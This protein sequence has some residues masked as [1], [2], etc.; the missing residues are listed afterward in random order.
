MTAPFGGTDSTD[1]GKSPF[2]VGTILG[3]WD[4]R[5]RPH[6]I[7]AIEAE[8]GLDESVYPGWVL[9]WYRDWFADT[10]DPEAK[11]KRS[12]DAPEPVEPMAVWP[13]AAS[14]AFRAMLDE[15]NRDLA[16]R[17]QWGLD[18]WRSSAAV[19]MR[20]D[21]ANGLQFHCDTCGHWLA[22]SHGHG[23][24]P[25]CGALMVSPATQQRWQRWYREG[26]LDRWDLEGAIVPA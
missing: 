21:D 23:R 24:C 3:E 19:A 5:F 17:A 15:R 10:G 6:D 1:G 13:T 26:T 20:Y 22:I 2:P 16:N 8:Y 12:A 9:A 7:K 18:I 4:S 11:D 14:T 25:T